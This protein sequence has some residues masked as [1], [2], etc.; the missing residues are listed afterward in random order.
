L[1]NPQADFG[2]DAERNTSKSDKIRPENIKIDEIA[3]EI[4][5]SMQRTR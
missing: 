1:L 4:I 3:D 2:Q 5:H